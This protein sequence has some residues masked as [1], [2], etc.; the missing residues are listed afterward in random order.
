MLPGEKKDVNTARSRFTQEEEMKKGLVLVLLLALL[1]TSVLFA[2]GGDEKAAGPQ[3]LRLGHIAA[4]GTAYDNY[5]HEFKRQVEEKTNGRYEIIILG[6]GQLGD[7]GPL[8]E[9]LQA[10]TIQFS[11]ITTSDLNL[12]MHEIDVLDLPFLFRDWEHVYKFLDSELYDEIMALGDQYGFKNLSTMPRGFRHVTMAN[13]PV[14]TPADLEGVK[15]RVA[16][17]PVYID[18]FKTLGANAQAMA[19]SEVYTALQQGTVEAHENT[20]I[21]TRDYNIDEVQN[22]LS[23]TGH[24][25]AFATMQTSLAWFNSIPEEDQKIIV[26]SALDAAYKLGLEQEADEAS[27]KAELIQEG[28]KI[29]AVDK[30]PFVNAMGPVIDKYAKGILKDYYEAIQAIK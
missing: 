3:E 15:M 10:G 23:E 16:E 8:M 26:E 17:S 1:S 29:N 27:A 4:P 9:G 5:A 25:F 12:Y 7:S 22:Y 24:V 11:I 13:N 6:G 2:Q 21:T 20:I 14:Y 28:M 18:T 30:A 19:W